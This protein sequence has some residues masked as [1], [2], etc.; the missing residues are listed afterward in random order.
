MLN[1]L[2][3][4]Q[5]NVTEGEKITHCDTH[6]TVES[7][8]RCNEDGCNQ[9]ICLKCSVRTSVGYRCLACHEKRKRI[10]YGATLLDNSVIFMFCFLAAIS[11]LPVYGLFFGT[12]GFVGF[13]AAIVGGPTSG[14][15]LAQVI[16]KLTQKRNS[17]YA[18][19]LALI[20]ICGGAIVGIGVA[21]FAID[22]MLWTSLPMYLFGITAGTTVIQLL[23]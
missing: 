17:R 20:G 2:A 21:S 3:N 8:L 15:V 9:R 4:Q 10:H 5:T 11:I 14:S 19:H 1:L 7:Y 16:R 23:K 13:W 6:P 12:L 22:F 18:V